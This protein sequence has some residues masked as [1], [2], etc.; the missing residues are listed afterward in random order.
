[1][2]DTITVTYIMTLADH[3]G[4]VQIHVRDMARWMGDQGH[5][6]H[7]LSGKPGIVSDAIIRNGGEFHDIP[8]MDRFIRLRD[9]WRAFWEIR[10]RLKQIKPDLVSCHSSKAGVIG[11][12]ATWSLGIPVIFTAHGWSF[13]EG[14]SAKRR[15]VFAMIERFCSLFGKHTITVSEY[16]R[17]LALRHRVCD[18]RAIRAIH[19]GMPDRPSVTRLS[20]N[21]IPQLVMIA[22]FSKQKDHET[23]LHALSLIK[24]QAWHLNLVGSGD[25]LAVRALVHHL[26][27]IDKITFHGQRT[28]IDAYL[29]TQDIFILSSHWEGFPRSILEAMRAGLPVITTNIAGCAESVIHGQ[30]GFVTP[31][32]NPE[33][34]A[35]AITQLL[36]NPKQRITM[37][38]QGRIQY[39]RYFT[40][41]RMARETF[42]V[43]QTVLD[44]ALVIHPALQGQVVR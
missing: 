30:T 13:T 5:C 7:V 37:G 35:D 18:P 41:D 1:M 11:R 39:E 44:P 27:L 25:D 24:D 16:D 9:D 10:R 29:N 12:I 8:H 23:L 43:Y 17:L 32:R 20:D 4:G 19:N 6:V 22:R 21:N 40:F 38:R 31:R 14:I 36:Q 15:R 26:D 28:D 2:K 3:Y 33:K 42:T 34:M